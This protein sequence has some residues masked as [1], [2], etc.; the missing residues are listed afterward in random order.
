MIIFC[1]TCGKDYE[2]PAQSVEEL[3]VHGQT[4]AECTCFWNTYS[5]KLS[6][7][8]ARWFVEWYPD[9]KGWSVML[10]G[11]RDSWHEHRYQAQ[12]RRDYLNSK[13]T[14]Q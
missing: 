13:I 6:K 1:S 12:L 9:V 2:S 8:D 3:R 4:C 7:S 14:D 5:H 10:D 11:F